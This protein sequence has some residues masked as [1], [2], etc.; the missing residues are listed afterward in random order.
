[1]KLNLVAFPGEKEPTVGQCLGVQSP[2]LLEEMVVVGCHDARRIVENRRHFPDTAE[3]L[4]RV[5]LHET[6]RQQLKLRRQ[7][8]IDENDILVWREVE[9]FARN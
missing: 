3:D 9:P 1:M 2:H 5:L 4:F 6:P 8:E 7:R